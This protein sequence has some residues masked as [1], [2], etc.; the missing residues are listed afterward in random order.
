MKTDYRVERGLATLLVS[1]FLLT[2]T[3]YAA[4]PFADVA[5]SDLYAPA[6]TYLKGKGVIEGYED[7][8]FQPERTMNRAEAL[9][10]LY[11]GVDEDISDETR[12]VFPDVPQDAWYARYVTHAQSQGVVK[13]YPDGTFQP[14]NTIN[15]AESLKILLNILRE[16]TS[17]VTQEDIA[18]FSRGQELWY[19]PFL[20]QAHRLGLLDALN[21]EDYALSGDVTRGELAEMLYRIL[22]LRE[23][24]LEVYDTAERGRIS[25]Y[26]DTLIGN[27]TSSGEPYR[28]E[29]FSA[30]HKEVPL[31]SYVQVVDA[32]AGTSLLVR[33][34]DRGPHTAGGVVD[35]AREA[36]KVFY[37]TSRGVFDGTVYKLPAT[38]QT[39]PKKYVEEDL[40]GVSGAEVLPNIFWQNEIYLLKAPESLPTLSLTLPSKKVMIVEPVQGVYQLEFPE[41]GKYLLERPGT[42]KE[43]VLEV[44]P[45]FQGKKVGKLSLLPT[46]EFHLDREGIATLAWTAPLPGNLLRLTITQGEQQSVLYVNPGEEQHVQLYEEYLAGVDLQK[47]LAITIERS[48]T[49]TRFSHDV[50]TDWERIGVVIEEAKTLA[51]VEEES[52]VLSERVSTSTSEAQGV[53]DRVNQERAKNG[54]QP[55]VLDATL[56]QM[57]QYKANDMANKN[58]F[59]HANAAGEDVNDWKSQFG[60]IGMVAENIAYSTQGTTANV[61]NLIKSPGHYANMIDP[62]FQIMGVGIALQNGKYYMTQ[63]FAAKPLS[64]GALSGEKG[65]LVAAVA[66]AGVSLPEQGALSTVAQRWAD[67]LAKEKVM[68]FVVD[69]KDVGDILRAE[70]GNYAFSFSVYGDVGLASLQRNLISRLQENAS[71][72]SYGIGLS[73]DS[74]GM[75]RLTVV[76]QK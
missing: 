72:H 18:T 8:T 52:G 13:G 68:S 2:G 10:M 63:H 15:K 11:E 56:N 61:E 21:P 47:A 27:K 59:S 39:Q 32:D 71:A 4:A 12:K 55:L 49:S 6:L 9:K 35:L 46:V 58:Y 28:A 1:A 17:V 38:L 7:G 24:N 70:I 19:A 64:G 45:R 67:Y 22:Y 44:L 14:G 51:P 34:N 53:L 20:L 73:Q 54:A 75:I 62:R 30:A 16:D 3:A 31:H 41:V 40:F 23:N 69:G 37:T 48:V 76:I 33:V 66:Q 74:T 5:E 36:F 60:F 65:T 43:V 57:A 26:S 29:I 42:G 25:Y 50:A